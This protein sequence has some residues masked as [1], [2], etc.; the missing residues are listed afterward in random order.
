M[1]YELFFGKS[2]NFNFYVMCIVMHA[3]LHILLISFTIST[4][5]LQHIDIAKKNI[6]I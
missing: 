2:N 4:R 1:N 3:K 6:Y 5:V